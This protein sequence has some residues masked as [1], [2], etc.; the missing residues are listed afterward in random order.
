MIRYTASSNLAGYSLSYNI[1]GSGVN[2][3]TG[4][5]DT[6]LN[7]AGDYQTLQVVEEYRSQE[8]PNDTAVA[9]NT[10]FLKI[11]QS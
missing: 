4:M 8:F 9:A 11:L 1:N 7:G 5:S 2:R 6:R 10:Y 3:G